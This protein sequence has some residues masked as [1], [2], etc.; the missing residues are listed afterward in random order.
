[1]RLTGFPWTQYGTLPGT[2]AQ[3]GGE[4]RDGR[5]RVEFLLTDHPTVPISLEHGLPGT[6]EVEVDRVSPATLVLRSAGQLVIG[7]NGPAA[8]EGQ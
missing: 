2:V 5:V 6:L 3:V 7:G 8:R 4:I 1:M